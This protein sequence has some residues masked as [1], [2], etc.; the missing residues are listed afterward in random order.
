MKRKPYQPSFAQQTRTLGNPWLRSALAVSLLAGSVVAEA[1]NYTIT[2]KVVAFDMDMY[3]GYRGDLVT[4]SFSPT[5]PTFTGTWSIDLGTNTFAGNINFAPYTETWSA[6][7]RY[8]DGWPT[9][10]PPPTT[11]TATHTV[12]NYQVSRQSNWFFESSPSDGR[13]TIYTALD[14]TSTSAI[15]SGDPCCYAA[16]FATKPGLAQAWDTYIRFN[17][18]SLQS[19]TANIIASTYQLQVTGVS[20]VPIPA[21]TWLF[22]SAVAGLA[23]MARMRRK[24]VA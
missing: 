11:G 10:P 1:T 14:L 15:Y 19:F 4:F 5:Q 7:P 23:G 18:P 6:G 13:P 12:D 24:T 8:W 9:P 21:A 22:G 17:D 16:P 3:P 20:T 2:G